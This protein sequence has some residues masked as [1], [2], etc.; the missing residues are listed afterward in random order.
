MTVLI[1]G[2]GAAG[3]TAAFTLLQEGFTDFKI[4]EASDR[5]GGRLKKLDG[6][7]SFPIDLGGEWLHVEHEVLQEISQDESIL[8]RVDT[9]LH[10][11]DS[12]RIWN[13]PEAGFGLDYMN[14]AT[15]EDL[16][17]YMFVNYTWFDFFN[18]TIAIQGVR[19]SVVFGC[20]VTT[21]DYS[22]AASNV[23]ATCSN[24]DTHQGTHIMVTAPLQILKDGDINFIPNL[25]DTHLDALANITMPPGYKIFLKFQQAFYPEMFQSSV[26]PIGLLFYDETY[27]ETTPEGEHIL[28][29]FV[30]DD[31]AE[32][33]AS[34]N[35]TI[36]LDHT[37]DLLDEMFDGSATQYFVEGVVQNWVQEPYIRGTYSHYSS[38]RDVDAL[39]E[40]ISVSSD[41]D[42]PVLFLAGE[43]LPA[44]HRDYGTA[45]AHGAALSGKETAEWILL[46]IKQAEG[47]GKVEDN[48]LQDEEA[49]NET[50]PQ[51][52]GTKNDTG[53]ED[54]SHTSP[55]EE[56]ISEALSMS[57]AGDT[58]YPISA[59]V[60]S[61]MAAA[62]MFFCM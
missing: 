4:L 45:M 37:L 51:T 9:V 42:R 44:T 55:A 58:M 31:A 14:F 24:G 13:G 6:F 15:E 30:S 32:E 47:G 5:L 43:A 1:V 8:D 2:A 39:K 20:Q 46:A 27:G 49:D 10:V 48:K 40:P 22:D 56:D 17:D 35:D 16:T 11:P 52:Q 62:T 23:T 25:P 33:S 57:S 54:T 41:E 12:Y 53:L 38:W 26:D 7:A 60:S 29:V 21:I 50:T 19:D 61:M 28:G 18:D 34:W 36:L 3:L 59:L